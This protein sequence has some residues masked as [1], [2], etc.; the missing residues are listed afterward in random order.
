MLLK[1]IGLFGAVAVT[2]ALTAG[3][4]LAK[5]VVKVGICVSWPGYSMYEVAK[6]KNLAP[7]YDIQEVIFEDP[8]GGHS[9]LASGQIDVYLCTNDY[10]PLI[11]ERGTDEVN[12]TY[13]NPSYGIDQIALAPNSEP[14]NLKGK[15]I[16][17][18]QAYIG[19]L[20]MGVWLDS[21]GIKPG[22][23]QWVNLNAD[24]AVGP[25]ISG[26]LAAAYLY[27]P[28]MS[29]LTGAL[30]GARSITNSA[31]PLFLKTG[32][33]MDVMYMN[34]KFIATRRKAALDMLRTHWLAV[35]A[36][37]DDTAAMNNVFAT[38]L[39]WPLGDVE[40]V[41]GTNGKSLKGGI[42]V[43]DFDEAARVCGVLPGDPPFGMTNG[44]AVSTEAL[45][46]DW[47]VK[48]GLMKTKVDA[49]KGLDCSLMGDLVKA[50]FRQSITAR[51]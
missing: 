34:K 10:T 15:K 29:K 33:F 42:Y 14:S 27:E 13:L 21:Q 36:W 44:A 23:V 28:W 48:L 24:E 6:A 3:A 12:V 26:D 17:A 31:D 46:N 2:A 1:R 4:A 7:D 49:T 25:M 30:K 16:A 5:D 39:K 45:I 43:Y 50:G 18:P 11:V 35:R 22:D 51:N 38:Y 37:H 32:I 19:Q 8:V 47:W 20:L 40:S 41:V 9:A